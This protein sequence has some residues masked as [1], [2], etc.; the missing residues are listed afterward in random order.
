[1]SFKQ[2]KQY[3]KESMDV[4]E[5][6]GKA[7]ATTVRQESLHCVAFGII[8][9]TGKNISNT[10][11]LDGELFGQSYDK[12]CNVDISLDSL[13]KFATDNPSWITAVVNNSNTLYNSKFLK[14]KYTYYRSN[15]VVKMIYDTF[16]TLTAQDG[17]K[18]N[19]DKWNPGDI[20]ASKLSSIPSFKSLSEF[21]E[22]ISKSLKS[23]KLIGISLKKSKGIPKIQYVEQSKVSGDIKFKGLKKPRSVFNTGISILT[24]DTNKSLNVRSFR[25]SKA[26]GIT[27]EIIDKSS[28]AR[29]GKAA[30]T[31][32]IKKHNIP[33][34][35]LSDFR[36]RYEE[37]EAMNNMIISLWKDAGHTFP[38]NKIDKDWKTRVSKGENMAGFYRSIINSLQVGVFLTQNKNIASKILTDIFLTASS[39][40]S[41]S[42]DFIKVY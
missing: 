29:H 40:G 22:F 38:Q 3:I 33:Q 11:L 24:D 4:N 37:T 21:N 25:I 34:M 31:K 39:M 35:T 13:Y 1:M 41:H 7:S 8:Q 17:I 5:V 20:W 23:G 2:F 15:G 14:G 27:S 19:A 36:R 10:E 42:S 26:A 12:Y 28:A 18:L 9:L 30:L 32:F 16:K 6:A